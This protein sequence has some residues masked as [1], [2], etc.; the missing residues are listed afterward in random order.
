MPSK[1][2]RGKSGI[3]PIADFVIETDWSAGQVVEAIDD[4]G[5]AEETIV[6]FTAD[7]GHSHYTGWQQLVAAGHQPSGTISNRTSRSRP[8]CRGSTRTS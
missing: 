1:D 5:L 3:A 8:T 2:F 4:A 6:V 7:N